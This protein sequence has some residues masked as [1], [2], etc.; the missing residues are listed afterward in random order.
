VHG[1]SCGAR[2]KTVSVRLEKG[3]A[4]SV[5]TVR[6][7]APHKET[8]D[9]GVAVDRSKR[10]TKRQSRRLFAILNANVIL[11]R[12]AQC[13]ASMTPPCDL[14]RHV[15]PPHVI[16]RVRENLP[17]VDIIC[18]QVRKQLAPSLRLD[19]LVSYGH[20]GLLAAARTFDESRG[21]PFRRWANIR[22]RGAV[23]DGIRAT[24]TLPRSAY[25]RFRAV[26]APAVLSNGLADEAADGAPNAE[27]AIV[28]AEIMARI[29]ECIGEL[30]GAQRAL[31]Q[32]H[33]FDDVTVDEAAAELGLSKSWASRLHGRAVEDVRRSLCSGASSDR[34]TSAHSM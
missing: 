19:D 8:A 21:V 20:E 29:R 4:V 7:T 31:L 25:A 23:I 28:R 5:R 12:L 26:D 14:H 18:D 15:D 30:P 32:R 9:K 6:R 22:V 1:H 2:V 27:D 16:D 13:A 11:A 33:Y 34:A 17:L 10:G 3:C 24:S